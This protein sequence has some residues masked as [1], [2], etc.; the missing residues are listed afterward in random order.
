LTRFYISCCAADAIPYSVF[1]RSTEDHRDDV[2]LRVDGRLGKIGDLFVV[3]P[4]SIAITD[5]PKTPYL[6]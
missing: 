1:I 4:R 6:F 3:D 2:W 5:E